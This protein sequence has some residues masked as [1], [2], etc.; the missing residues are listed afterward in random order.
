MIFSSTTM[1]IMTILFLF[2]LCFYLIFKLYKFSLII[3]KIEDAIEDSLD[4]LDRNYKSMSEIIKKPVFFDSLEIRQV[5][6]QI[7]EC[8]SSILIV[9]NKLTNDIGLISEI[10]EKISKIKE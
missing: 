7:S 2:L 1:F 8:H 10:K 3:I 4:V 6:S 9:A 5:I